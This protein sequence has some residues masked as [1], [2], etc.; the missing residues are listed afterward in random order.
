MGWPVLGYL[1]GKNF[2]RRDRDHLVPPRRM[3]AAVYRAEVCYPFGRGHGRHRAVRRREFIMLLGG[4]AAAWPLTARAQQP[5]MPVIGF[6]S[7]GMPAGYALYAT[8]LRQGLKEAGYIEGQNLAIEY[9]WAEGRNDLLPALAADLVGRPVAVIAA[10]GVSAALA[11]KAATT[12]IPIVFEGG[13]DP[14]ELGLVTSLNRPSG[15]VTGVS[16]FSAVLVAKQIEL[17]HEM[18]PNSTVIGV[19]VNPTS[20]SLAESTARDAQ[21]AGRA[22]GKQIHILN[23]S[24]EDQID[25][26]FATLARGR[27]DA[28]LIG[29]D[30]FFVSRRAQ[31]I[32]MA[33]RN[34]LPTIYNAREVPAAGGL[35]SYGASLVDAYRQTGVYTGKILKGAKPAELPVMQ[36][37]KFVLVINLTTAKAFGLKI[38]PSLL[39]RADEVIE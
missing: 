9:R 11:A 8:A 26:A 10:A 35:M 32:T 18:L 29:G 31:L 28:L 17:L 3:D 23:A 37:T 39:A 22:L 15:N 34:G 27:T 7:G 36:P 1:L 13:L 25:A 38:P 30:A 20:P 12:T 6:L 21:A 2:R 4:A 19:L 33:T 24:T 14:V 5:A 16:N